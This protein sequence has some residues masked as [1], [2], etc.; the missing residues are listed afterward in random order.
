MTYFLPTIPHKWQNYWRYRFPFQKLRNLRTIEMAGNWKFTG[1]SAQ[2][3][4]YLSV[5][6]HGE[7]QT[8]KL[9]TDQLNLDIM[10]SKIEWSLFF[11]RWPSFSDVRHNTPS[12]GESNFQGFIPRFLHKMHL[13]DSTC[14]PHRFVQHLFAPGDYFHAFF[15]SFREI[16]KFPLEFAAIFL[17][18]RF[19]WRVPTRETFLFQVSR[20][21]TC[22][23]PDLTLFSRH[24]CGWFYKQAYLH[25]IQNILMS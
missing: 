16:N 22:H 8:E 19:L 25:D 17:F 13:I 20:D 6:L 5:V 3:G 11:D 21:F 10:T 9:D 18:L 23:G 24:R 15:A 7:L 1:A 4:F 12:W 14:N 2:T